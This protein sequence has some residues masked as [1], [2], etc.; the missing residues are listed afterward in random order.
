LFYAQ[1]TG[2]VMSIPHSQNAFHLPSILSRFARHKNSF[3][4]P[5]ENWLA[6][7][8]GHFFD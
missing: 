8:D 4:F 7:L 2:D 1:Q 6:R 5:P 3:T